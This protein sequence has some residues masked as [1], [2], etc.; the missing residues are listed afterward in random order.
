MKKIANGI[1]INSEWDFVTKEIHLE[2]KGR[3]ISEAREGL[4]KLIKEINKLLDKS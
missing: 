1:T 3:T 4:N 2:S